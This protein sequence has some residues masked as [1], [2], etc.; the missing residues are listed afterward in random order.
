M[1]PALGMVSQVVW[2]GAHPFLAE[3][4]DNLFAIVLALNF[5]QELIVLLLLLLLY[6]CRKVQF[7][8]GKLPQLLGEFRHVLVHI[9]FSFLLRSCRR[10]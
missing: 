7:V 3:R 1:A 8:V 9:L 10:F 6:R 4:A 2:E 5:P